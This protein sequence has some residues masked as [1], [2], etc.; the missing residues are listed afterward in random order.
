M[1]MFVLVFSLLF[2][3]HLAF[4]SQALID[5]ARDGDLPQVTRLIGQG[6]NVNDY[7][8]WPL[9]STALIRAANRGNIHVVQALL[10][11]PE[12]HINCKDNV[13]Y[14]ALIRAAAS[15]RIEVVQALLAR[16]NIL[17]NLADNQGWTPL[18]WAAAH[19][20]IEVVQALLARPEILIN[21]TNSSGDTALMRAEEN[22]HTVVAE[23]IRDVSLAR[24]QAHLISPKVEEVTQLPLVLSDIISNYLTGLDHPEYASPQLHERAEEP[25]GCG[26]GCA[27]Q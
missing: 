27:I 3:S 13:G 15:G 20:R 11:R 12:I 17:V 22:G 2:S 6:D 4:A 8:G 10:A 18:V 1:K 14:T 5:A 7:L 21:H 9:P 23:M 16:P 24:S 19:G 26:C 25:R